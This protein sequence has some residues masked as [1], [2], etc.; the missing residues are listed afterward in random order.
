MM[1]PGVRAAALHARDLPT[2]I[3]DM[4][5]SLYLLFKAVRE[6]STVALSGESADEV[7][8]GYRDFHDADT[9]AAGHLPVAGRP[10]DEPRRDRTR[11]LFDPDLFESSTCA[12]YVDDQYRTALAE[13][14]ELTGP[15]P[16]TRTSG[17]CAR[18]A[19]S[20]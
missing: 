15:A 1:D 19:T 12:G 4:D 11:A 5:T 7:F 6:E 14:P 18:S 20:T 2:G 13:V 16:R 3:G 9:V 10:D 8:G 17:G